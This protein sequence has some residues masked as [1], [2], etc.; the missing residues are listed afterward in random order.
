MKAKI[1]FLHKPID[2]RVTEVELPKLKPDQILVQLKACGI[3]GSD[4]VCFEGRFA[5]GRYDIG[6]LH[7][8]T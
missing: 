4:V 1:A 6:P 8:G 3:C 5:E 7:T 2:L